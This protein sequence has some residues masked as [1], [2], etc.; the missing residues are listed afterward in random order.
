[1]NIKL[2]SIALLASLV[3]ATVSAQTPA[4]AEKA[5]PKVSVGIEKCLPTVLKEAPGEVLQ[6]VLKSEGGKASWEIEIEGQDG[7]LHDIECSGVTG[8]I[9]ER[10]LRVASAD[11]P[12]FKE[13][14]KVSEAQAQ[15]TAL[16]K[17][18]GSVERV[19]Y[20]IEADGRVVYEFDIKPASGHD[21]RVEV[22]ATTGEITEASPEWLEIGRL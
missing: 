19:E 15:A 11:A 10:E 12:G 17:Y 2:P 22:D 9:T 1:M 16:A 20:E 3:A 5:A 4:K 13:K 8:K 7:K 21:W 18:P 14:V 6:V